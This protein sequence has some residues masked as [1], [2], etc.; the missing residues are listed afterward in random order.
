MNKRNMSNNYKCEHHEQCQLFGVDEHEDYHH[1]NETWWQCPSPC[2]PLGF[3]EPLK[4]LTSVDQALHLN[5]NI[6]TIDVLWTGFWRYKFGIQCCAILNTHEIFLVQSWDAKCLVNG[7][8]RCLERLFLFQAIH[9]PLLGG[10]GDN[11]LLREQ[12]WML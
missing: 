6:L 3:D 7:G 4:H 9:H 10:G 5:R 1:N 8:A 11:F 2:K 12:I